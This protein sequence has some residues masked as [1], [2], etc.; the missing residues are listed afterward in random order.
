MRLKEWLENEKEKNW[1]IGGR[2]EVSLLRKENPQATLAGDNFEANCSE[3]FSP[4]WKK[5]NYKRQPI[6]ILTKQ[7]VAIFIS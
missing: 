4:E 1:G 6:T 2:I 3:I 7:S 5:K